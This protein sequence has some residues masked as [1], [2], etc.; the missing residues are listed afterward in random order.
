VDNPT[1]TYGKI[2]SNIGGSFSTGGYAGARIA[3]T[4]PL[5]LT[6]GVKNFYDVLE[7]YD[8]FFHLQ[9]A[10]IYFISKALMNGQHPLDQIPADMMPDTLEF[11]LQDFSMM[12]SDALS[13]V[14]GHSSSLR[15]ELEIEKLID[16]L[17]KRLVLA[18]RFFN[19]LNYDFII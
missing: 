4:K 11:T 18:G 6:C 1:I 5:T 10:H 15:L 17:Q 8:I 14:L 3:S 16:F 12:I 13:C 9:E 7:K 2:L 19:K